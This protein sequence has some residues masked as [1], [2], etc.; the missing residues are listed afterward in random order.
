MLTLTREIEESIIIGDNIKLTIK[1]IKGNQVSIGVDA[2][3]DV[4]VIRP[5]AKNRQKI[6]ER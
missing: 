5:E 3:K 2:P 1:G 4:R 6:A